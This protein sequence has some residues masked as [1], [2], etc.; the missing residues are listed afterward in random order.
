VRRWKVRV[1]RVWRV[2]GVDEMERRGREEGAW[3]VKGVE[4]MERRGGE[5]RSVEGGG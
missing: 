5:G 2:E 3:R 1:E 4:E